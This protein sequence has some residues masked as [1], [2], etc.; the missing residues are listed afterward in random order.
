[1][2]NRTVLMLKQ[3]QFPAINSALLSPSFDTSSGYLGQIQIHLPPSAM[4]AGNGSELAGTPSSGSSRC[5]KLDV[6]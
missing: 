4:M 2:G 3:F 1:M 6:I 5:R